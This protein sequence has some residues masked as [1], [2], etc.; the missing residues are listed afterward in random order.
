MTIPGKCGVLDNVEE[1][2]LFSCMADD[3]LPDIGVS[4]LV[5]V[6]DP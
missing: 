3:D 6:G 1:W 4:F 5:F 2:F